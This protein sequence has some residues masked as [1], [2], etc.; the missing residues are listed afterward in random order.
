MCE[1]VGTHIWPPVFTVSLRRCVFNA[2][3]HTQQKEIHEDHT[4]FT[5]V[6]D[7]DGRGGR[8]PRGSFTCVCVRTSVENVRAAIDLSVHMSRFF[9]VRLHTC[10]S[11][12]LAKKDRTERKKRKRKEK[13][14]KDPSRWPGLAA[15]S[16]SFLWPFHSATS[17]ETFFSQLLL[18]SARKLT[19]TPLFHQGRGR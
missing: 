8:A 3:L 1:V 14:E 9:T 18:L 6:S 10:A 7:I 5:H 15:F 2:H 19:H 17:A 12:C 16:F 4:L 11:I 13:E